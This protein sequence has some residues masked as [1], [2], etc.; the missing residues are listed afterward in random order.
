MFPPLFFW[1]FVSRTEKTGKNGAANA[2]P[3]TRNGARQN[4]QR[5]CGKECACQDGGKT[6]VLHS[7]LN[8]YGAFLGGVE[9]GKS[10]RQP[11]QKIAQR[12]VAEHNSESPDEQHEAALHQRVVNGGDYSANNTCQQNDT[13]AGHQCL[14]CLETVALAIIVIQNASNTDRQDGH[15]QNVKKHAHSVYLDD[16]A[17]SELHQQWSHHRRKHR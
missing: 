4:R 6:S 16:C 2:V 7:H 15:Y 17:R 11:T 8:G 14:Q 12:V 13:R 9:T 3:R 5:L 10:A 1:P